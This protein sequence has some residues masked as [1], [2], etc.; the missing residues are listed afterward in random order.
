MCM[1]ECAG[2]MRGAVSVSADSCLYTEDFLFRQI[3]ENTPQPLAAH[4][5]NGMQFYFSTASGLAYA[6]TPFLWLVLVPR[7]CF[8]GLASA[9]VPSASLRT[10]LLG[11]Q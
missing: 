9:R 1:Y 5:V 6:V 2:A 7:G 4:I 11:A 10:P 8:A 3:Y